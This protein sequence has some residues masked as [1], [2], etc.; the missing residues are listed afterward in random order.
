MKSK[1]FAEGLVECSG[2]GSS[3][4][5]NHGHAEMVVDAHPQS[6]LTGQT[7]CVE[8]DDYVWAA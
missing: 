3:W 7:E 2:C 1:Q 4:A 5:I 6:F 8:A